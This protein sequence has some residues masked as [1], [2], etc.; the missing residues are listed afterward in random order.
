MRVRVCGCVY[1]CARGVGVLGL[2]F[3]AQFFVSFLVLQSSTQGRESWLLDFV[4]FLLL[5]DC[6]CSVSLPCGAV[7]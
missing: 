4:V 1:L 6:L 5:C 7:G 3:M 2:C